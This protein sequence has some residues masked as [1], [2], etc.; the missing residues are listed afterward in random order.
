MREIVF[1]G[2]TLLGKWIEG[3][4][5][6]YLGWGK[7][8]IAQ[9][10]MGAGGQEVIPETVGQYTGI[11]DKKGKRIFEGDILKADNGHI[12]YVTFYKGS[13]VKCCFCH[14]GSINDIYSDN[15]TVIGNKYDNPELRAINDIF[16][17]RRQ[18]EDAAVEEFVDYLKSTQ[19]S[20]FNHMDMDY[21]EIEDIE[22]AE[23]EFKE[24][25]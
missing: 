22:L 19:V 20:K 17:S 13:F 23:K 5:L 6:Q 3:D 25:L 9:N 8:H 4:L 2:K 15:E 11:T 12:G 1:K 7:V 21:I 14:A 18:I 16:V 24:R 10:Y